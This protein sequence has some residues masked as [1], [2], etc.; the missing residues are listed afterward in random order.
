MGFIAGTYVLTKSKE[1]RK[2]GRE[3]KWEQGRKKGGREGQREGGRRLFRH[4]YM[5]FDSCV[6][7]E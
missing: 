1:G 3:G 6:F 2:E 4:S 5:L 7:L